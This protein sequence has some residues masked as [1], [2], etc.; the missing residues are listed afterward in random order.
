[1]MESYAPENAGAKSLPTKLK[2]T[3]SSILGRDGPRRVKHS[4]K[5]ALAITVVS[6]IYY[7]WK[8]YN[9]FGLN[10]IWAMVTVV[11]VFEYTAGATV[12]RGLN[13][14]FASFLAGALAY[15]ADQFATQIVGKY[16]GEKGVDIAFGFFV[17]IIAT[18]ATF[19][20]FHPHI[21]ARDDYGVMIFILTFSFVAV[22]GSRVPY[23]FK[24]AR[25]RLQ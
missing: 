13:R 11:V 17:F 21:K 22:Y 8:L 25:E 1:M 18:G 15:G 20:R 16:L 14:G 19:T 6:L 23:D 24:I 7:D 4:L 9:A 2:G 3:V 5:V 12:S 10:G